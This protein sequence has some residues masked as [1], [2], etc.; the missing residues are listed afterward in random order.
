MEG[1]RGGLGPEGGRAAGLRRLL[2]PP[3]LSPG[4]GGPDPGS[5]PWPRRA[6]RR[7][8]RGAGSGAGREGELPPPCLLERRGEAGQGGLQ[9][10]GLGLGSSGG[11]RAAGCRLQAGG[12]RRILE[13]S[14][15][16]PRQTDGLRFGGRALILPAA[17]NPFYCQADTGLLSGRGA[18][19]RQLAKQWRPCW[20]GPPLLGTEDEGAGE[21]QA[22]G[23][24]GVHAAPCN[25]RLTCLSLPR[26]G[27]R[28]GRSA[29]MPQ[30]SGRLT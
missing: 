5:G 4:S 6:A 15:R 20:P 25:W 28:V 24:R 16:H 14:P 3:L 12:V 13:A 29:R 27:V 22:A 21:L 19:A 9:F 8:G 2:P 10:G 11:P 1:R 30:A 17:F 23:I 7:R 18:A 26:G